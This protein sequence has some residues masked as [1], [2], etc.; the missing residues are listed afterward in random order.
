MV[1]VEGGEKSGKSYSAALLSSSPRVGATFWIDLGEGSADEYGAIPGVRYEVVEH[2]GD[3]HQILA[4]VREVKAHARW[5]AD[6]GQPPTVLVIDTVSDLWEAL[7][8]FATDR[9]RKRKKLAADAEVTVSM[10]LW[11]EANSRHRRVMTELLTFPGIVVLLARGKDVAALDDN[12]KPIE[13]QKDYKVEGQKN[14]AYD[15]TVWVRMSRT[16]KPEIIGARSVHAGIRP[17]KDESQQVKAPEAEA[18][19]LDWLVFDALRCDPRTAHVRDIKQTTAGAL[20]PEEGGE[21]PRA[22]AIR[23]EAMSNVVTF[24]RVGVLFGEAKASRLDALPVAQ[25]DGELVPLGK[26]LIDRGNELRPRPVAVPASA[27]VVG[28]QE[29]AA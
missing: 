15:A 12:G 5:A 21:D 4:R 27:P 3:Y 24:E 2:N 18:N 22:A 7:K 6:N 29:A 1:L 20:L 23:D 19:L 10:D 28:G 14:I 13:R 16:R 25:P 11:N 8:D 26:L 17:G 9:A